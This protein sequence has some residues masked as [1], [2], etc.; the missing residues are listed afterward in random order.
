MERVELDGITRV[1]I[2]IM[3]ITHHGIKSVE[4]IRSNC[5]QERL[6]NLEITLHQSGT[7]E[8]VKK[9]QRNIRALCC[10]LRVE[11]F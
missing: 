5:A 1:I 9:K 8:A 3:H 6:D 11:H 10:L 2:A 7:F 4:N